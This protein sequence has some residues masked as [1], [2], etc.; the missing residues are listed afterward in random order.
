MHFMPRL[1]CGVE[2]VNN[3][4]IIFINANDVDIAVVQKRINAVISITSS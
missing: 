4:I 1:Q 2:D 3:K